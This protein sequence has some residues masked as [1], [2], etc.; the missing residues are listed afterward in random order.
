[1]F[2]PENRLEEHLMAAARDPAAR[3]EFYRELIASDLLVVDEGRVPEE[4]GRVTLQAGRQLRIRN[5]EFRGQSYLPVF[6]SL[7]RLRAG[8]T[9]T[10]RY[11]AMNALELLKITRGA[12]LVLNPGSDFGKE[13]LPEE[14]ESIID[15][16]ILRPRE[17]Y[18]VNRPTEVMLG[19]PARYPTEL[20]EVLKRVF[21]R[22]DGVRAAFLAHFINPAKDAK[23]HTLIAIDAK[24]DWD[25]IVSE[26]GLA[27]GG[28]TV[29]DPPVDFMRLPNSGLDSYFKTVAPFYRRKVFGLF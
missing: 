21:K 6:S 24:G 15:G 18:I 1:M 29:P 28:V 11:L 16:S 17:S 8:I 14:V 9:G 2:V 10:V 12:K 13:L 20:V 4:T 26:A 7:T 22:H 23:A 27:A 25:R 5:I 19:Q 3:G